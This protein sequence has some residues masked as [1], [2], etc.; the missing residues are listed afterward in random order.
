M[1]ENR[2][3]KKGKASLWATDERRRTVKAM[4]GAFR[5]RKLRG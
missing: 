3:Y 4:A 5:R 1:P 2:I